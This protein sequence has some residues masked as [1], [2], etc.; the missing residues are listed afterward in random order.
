LLTAACGLVAVGGVISSRVSKTAHR[1]TS[2]PLPAYEKH[3]PLNG[4]ATPRPVETVSMP[5]PSLASEP[6]APT[7]AGGVVQIEAK[8]TAPK[9][10]R[11]GGRALGRQPATSAGSA[12]DGH[13]PGM[14]T[15]SR[16]VGKGAFPRANFD[17]E[18][19]YGTP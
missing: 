2:A 9:H 17:P 5:A 7:G 8:P 11:I 15:E 18:N 14:P 10:A 4:E 1:S 6:A 13:E 19:P 12:R 16:T 3:V